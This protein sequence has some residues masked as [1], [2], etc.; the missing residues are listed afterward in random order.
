MKKTVNILFV[1]VCIGLCL[2]LFIC[3]SFAKTDSTTENKRLSQLPKLY[4]KELNIDFLSEMG[5]YFGD[6]FA[7]R[8]NLVD[9]D[10]RIQSGIFG[11]SNMDTVIKGSDG[12]LYYTDSLDDYLRKNT[13]SK[14]S[15]KSIARNL[16]I[17]QEYV[18]SRGAEFVFTVA[19]N[20]N[21]LYDDNMPYYHSK[22]SGSKKNIDRLNPEL[23]DI[24]YCDLFSLF[25]S[26]DEILYH[27]RDSHWNNKGAM[28]VFSEIMKKLGKPCT[29]Y[30]EVNAVKKKDFIG[31]LGRMLYPVSAEPEWNYYYDLKHYTSDFDSVEA[32]Y[33]HT[34]SDSGEGTLLMFRDSFGNSLLP[35]FSGEFDTAAFSKGIPYAL[36]EYMDELNPEYVVIEKVERNLDEL[37]GEPPVMTG[38]PAGLNTEIKTVKSNSKLS[39]SPSEANCAYIEIKGEADRRFVTDDTV[40]YI[41]LSSGQSYEALN[42]FSVTSDKSD[43]GFLLYIPAERVAEGAEVELIA[44]NGKEQLSLINKTV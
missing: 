6:H 22:K 34:K 13:L 25:G 43:S 10:S 31:D 38:T 44:D 35:F 41:K 8:N 2:S 32:P 29:D 27:K 21:S 4:D 20:K 3:M 9:M 19:P 33:I 36:E 7:F 5:E 24:N 37:C 26:Q 18:R 42:A 23:K 30:S 17:V 1:A 15:V 14:R 12:W 28:L 16:S 39:V 40:F 11:V